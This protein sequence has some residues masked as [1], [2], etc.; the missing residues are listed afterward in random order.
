M[1][2][3]ATNIHEKIR[4]F[5]KKYYLN[6]FIRGTLLTFSVLIGYF[7]LASLIEHNLW[8]GPWARLLIF[9]AFFGLAAY[10]ALKYL[11]QPFR[12]WLAK[13]GLNDEEAARIIGQ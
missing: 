6:I 1:S 9:L 11:N 13:R 4:S 10:C 8:L 2:E 5:Q 12:W 3:G 7:L